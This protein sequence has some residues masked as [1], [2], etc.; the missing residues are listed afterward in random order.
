MRRFLNFLIFFE[1]VMLNPSLVNPHKTPLT[2]AKPRITPLTLAPIFGRWISPTLAVRSSLLEG[3]PQ[4]P[5]FWP[6]AV[7]STPSRRNLAQTVAIG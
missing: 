2:E 5:A 4:T 7:G 6:L 1:L 3:N